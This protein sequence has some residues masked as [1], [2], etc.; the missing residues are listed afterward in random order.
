M[1]VLRKVIVKIVN[2][3]YNV[4]GFFTIDQYG[5]FVKIH[6]LFNSLVESVVVIPKS[7]GITPN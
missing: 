7:I 6:I 2:I 5:V 1:Y 3:D 4:N